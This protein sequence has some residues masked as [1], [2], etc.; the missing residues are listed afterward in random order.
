[1]DKDSPCIYTP[2]SIYNRKENLGASFLQFF[3]EV[4]S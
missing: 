1:L 2:T 4:H 3:F